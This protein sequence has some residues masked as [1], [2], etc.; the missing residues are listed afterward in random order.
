MQIVVV[1][2]SHPELPLTVLEGR[3]RELLATGTLVL[4]FAPHVHVE[5]L[6]AAKSASCHRVL[7]RGKLVAEATE[8]VSSLFT[9]LEAESRP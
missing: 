7:S 5:K 3:L 4:A 9:S 8:I 1:D 2:L 6:A